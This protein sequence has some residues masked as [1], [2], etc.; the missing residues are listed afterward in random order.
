MT[1]YNYSSSF[2]LYQIALPDK[3]QLR[4]KLNPFS[5]AVGKFENRWDPDPEESEE[6]QLLQKAEIKKEIKDFADDALNISADADRLIT[7]CWNTMGWDPENGPSSELR[8]KL[9]SL[10]G[11]VK[12]FRGS[13]KDWRSGEK[14]WLPPMSKN[15]KQ[16]SPVQNT[17]WTKKKIRQ[18]KNFYEE[19][20][21]ILTL[22]DEYKNDEQN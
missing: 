7:D 14:K 16:E 4:G 13:V 1:I 15:E 11:K 17:E 10:K 3:S 20:M 6:P 22:V 8:T 18:A 9:K 2:C 21:V 19:F 5:E 12:K